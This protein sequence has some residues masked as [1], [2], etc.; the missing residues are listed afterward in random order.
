MG[1]GHQ[2]NEVFGLNGRA[3]L[4]NDQEREKQS[5]LAAF[6]SRFVRLTAVGLYR[7]IALSLSCPPSMR[8]WCSLGIPWRLEMRCSRGCSRSPSDGMHMSTRKLT[9]IKNVWL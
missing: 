1:Y 2:S 8:R 6:L 7:E 3:T 4:V 5:R 9:N